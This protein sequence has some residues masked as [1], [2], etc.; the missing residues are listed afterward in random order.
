MEKIK[1]VIVDDHEIV[2]DGLVALLE[3]NNKFNII[4]E[5]QDATDLFNLLTK[6]DPDIILLDINLPGLSGIEIA[7]ILTTDYPDIKI[8]MLSADFNQEL[9]FNA[10]EAGVKG[11]LP[12]KTA[13]RELID[14]IETV[15]SGEEYFNQL[16][17][18]T[19]FKSYLASLKETKIP[20]LTADE[21]E[22][23]EREKEIVKWF[24]EGYSYK[25][26]AAKL[27]ISVR[28]VE[29]HKNNIMEKMGFH[30]KVDMV[31]YAIKNK[32][33]EL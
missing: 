16:I 10:I 20:S 32:L 14:A 8:I 9:I 1:I 24:A 21:P 12:K 2:R 3:V 31:K 22:L 13:V 4:G 5:A 26:I 19:M 28:T 25:E 27:F 7:R 30:S 29:S 17:T 11:Y 6:K 23:S 33:I 15:F 18:N